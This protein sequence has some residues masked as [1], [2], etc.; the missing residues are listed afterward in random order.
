MNAVSFIINDHAENYSLYRPE[1]GKSR[2]ALII[3]NRSSLLVPLYSTNG[4]A[5]VL[6]PF[7]G[8]YIVYS[9]YPRR[10]HGLWKPL[11]FQ[12]VVA[13]TNIRHRY[14]NRSAECLLFCPMNHFIPLMTA[15]LPTCRGKSLRAH[16]STS[17]I[18][19]F[20]FLL[21]S[22]FI[23][24]QLFVLLKIV[25]FL[26]TFSTLFICYLDKCAYLCSHRR[27]RKKTVSDCRSFGKFFYLPFIL[28]TTE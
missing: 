3:P 2:K 1:R 5:S 23:F 18:F 8:R 27:E 19:C 14:P 28:S 15:V 25:C 22:S 7:T 21:M 4:S 24:V 12:P 10:C 20:S 26:F 17:R 13:P 9:F 16:R 11:G 6:L